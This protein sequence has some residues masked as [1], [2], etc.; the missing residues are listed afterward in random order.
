MSDCAKERWHGPAMVH[1]YEK[2][3]QDPD[4][5]NMLRRSCVFCSRSAVMAKPKDWDETTKTTQKA[6]SVETSNG[7]GQVA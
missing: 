5:E 1:Q 3:E 2:W 4:A 7:G 6:S